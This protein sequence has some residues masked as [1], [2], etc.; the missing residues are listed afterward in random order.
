[1]VS[2]KTWCELNGDFGKKVLADYIDEKDI[3]KIGCASKI[4]L[5]FRCTECGNEFDRAPCHVTRMRIC[6]FCNP[7]NHCSDTI[8]KNSKR[9]LINSYPEIADEYSE[10]NDEP[11]NTI[12]SNSNKKKIWV[13]KT[14]GNKWEAIVANRTN[15]NS[16]CPKCSA[17]NQASLMEYMIYL[18]ISEY[19]DTEYHYKVNGMSFDIGINKPA[20]LIEYQG[21]YTHSN[22]FQSSYDVEKRDKDKREFV[23]SHNCKFITINETYGGEKIKAVGN[24]IYFNAD[25]LKKL[26]AIRA[27]TKEL[28]AI[29]NCN[30][31][32]RDD[33][34]SYAISRMHIKDIEESLGKMYPAIA[35]EWN[36]ERNGVMTPLKIKPKSNKLV[37][38]KCKKCGY[39]W[40]TSPAHRVVDNTG[41]QRCLVASGSGAGTHAVF[42]GINDLK[43]LYPEIAKEYMNDKNN[44]DISK[45]AAKSNK[46]VWWKCSCCGKEYMQKV[47][48][49]TVRNKNCPICNNQKLLDNYDF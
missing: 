38:W 24:D 41:C 16:G 29:L 1:M 44:I 42:E 13:C 36:T 20:T 32:V 45:I 12:L 3:S 48:Y 21:R 7:L 26:D 28:N 8:D 5:K 15:K 31:Q 40:K 27:I 46:E 17:G 47:V 14:C 35:E 49:R 4:K 37:W 10:E 25:N 30:M 6:P 18:V 39:E 9:L 23:E 19:F 43:T 33:I 34:E 22:K 2:L 11:L